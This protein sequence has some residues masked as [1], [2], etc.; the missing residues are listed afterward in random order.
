MNY[1]MLRAFRRRMAEKAPPSTLFKGT[2]SNQKYTSGSDYREAIAPKEEHV[3]NWD[4][5]DFEQHMISKSSMQVQMGLR[6]FDVKAIEVA[7]LH[8]AANKSDPNWV[9]RMKAPENAVDING[10][11]LYHEY[12]AEN[13]LNTAENSR[14]VKNE[15][16]EASS[17][18]SPDQQGARTGGEVGIGRVFRT[19]S[20]PRRSGHQRSMPH[21]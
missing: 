5:I 11:I 16:Y 8:L 7:D 18:C 14:R 1:Y 20:R 10:I 19:V 2:K 17:K 4:R 3:K 6:D 12:M 21:H 13:G 9:K 15:K